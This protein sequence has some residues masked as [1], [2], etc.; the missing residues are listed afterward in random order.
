MN[1]VPD[2][3]LDSTHFLILLNNVKLDPTRK[4]ALVTIDI[5]AMYTNLPINVCK[6]HCINALTKFKNKCNLNLDVSN[7]QFK[8]LLDL[9]LDYSYV[10]YDDKY[11]FQHRGIQMGGSASVSIANITVFEEL[12]DIF[13]NVNEFVFYKRFLDDIFALVDI[14]DLENCEYWLTSKLKH[15][16]LTFTHEVSTTSIV[17]LDL[18]ISL[19]ENNNINTKIY[20]KPMSKSQPVLYH[21]NHRKCLLNSIPYAQGLRIIRSCTNPLDVQNELSILFKSFENRMYPKKV[22][23][24][25][26]VKLQNISREY[27]LTPRKPLLLNNLKIH[28]PDILVNLGIYPNENEIT[29]VETNDDYNIYFV[30][31]Y[32]NCI[33]NYTKL[34]KNTV[35]NE[36]TKCQEPELYTAINSCNI[37]VSYSKVNCLKSKI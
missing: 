3:I 18:E 2:I 28:H 10:E 15:N 22:L 5:S 29:V 7:E 12:K 35:I 33:G 1:Y 8:Q 14:T 25:T 4:Y 37:V 20:R 26:I 32:Y 23:N 34:I 9:C 31:P 21:S 19:S 6:K 13:S 36:L 24:E 27:I 16:F 17:F 30:M 11:Y